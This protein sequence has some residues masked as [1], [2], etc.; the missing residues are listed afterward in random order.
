MSTFSFEHPVIY[1]KKCAVAGPILRDCGPLEMVTP[2]A[3]TDTKRED[4]D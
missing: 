2:G 3:G 1:Q 4:E